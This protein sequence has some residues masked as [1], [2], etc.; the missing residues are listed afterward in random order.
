V[1]KFKVKPLFF[2]IC[3][4]GIILGCWL[5]YIENELYMKILLIGI[6]VVLLACFVNKAFKVF[7]VDDDTITV[8]YILGNKVIL[9]SEIDH[10]YVYA[11]KL[12][13]IAFIICSKDDKII[14]ES[15]IENYKRLMQILVDRCKRYN[16]VRIESEVIEYLKK[17]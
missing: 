8:K 13:W 11:K 2:L 12:N 16:N 5:I 15:G 7:I 3:L 6:M 1:E 4:A 14:I 17:Y 10:I 9:W